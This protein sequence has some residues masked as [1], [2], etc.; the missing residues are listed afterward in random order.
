MSSQISILETLIKGN[1][2]LPDSPVS[3]VNSTV[4]GV[5]YV[6]DTKNFIMS[7]T[8]AEDVEGLSVATKLCMIVDGNVLHKYMDTMNSIVRCAIYREN[9]GRLVFDKEFAKKLIR[10]KGTLIKQ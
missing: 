3:I 5:I 7:S 8:V 2:H 10:E 4:E 6:K 1:I 9:G